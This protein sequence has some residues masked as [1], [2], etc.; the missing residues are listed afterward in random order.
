MPM[1]LTC[2]GRTIRT[3]CIAICR[4]CSQSNVRVPVAPPC[5]RKRRSREV[6]RQPLCRRSS[7]RWRTKRRRSVRVSSSSRFCSSL[8]TVFVERIR[9][10][11]LL[12][13]LAGCH[14]VLLSRWFTYLHTKNKKAYWSFAWILALRFFLLKCFHLHDMILIWS[15]L[16]L[17]D[18]IR[19][20]ALL[21]ITK[22]KLMNTNYEIL[23]YL[24]FTHNLINLLNNITDTVDNPHHNPSLR[25]CHHWIRDWINLSIVIWRQ[26]FPIHAT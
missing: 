21:N 23:H 15:T 1:S 26:C 4:P 11:L 17:I 16:K 13:W 6:W 20:Y 22:Q 14:A 18:T 2:D 19:M 7:W 10:Y 5:G 8:Q 9:W 3:S 12:H 25:F 24:M